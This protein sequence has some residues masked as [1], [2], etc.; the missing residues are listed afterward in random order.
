MIQKK[1]DEFVNKNIKT[2][3]LYNDRVGEVDECRDVFMGYLGDVERR[4]FQKVISSDK[5]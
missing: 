1:I 5:Q 3:L 2:I 4:M